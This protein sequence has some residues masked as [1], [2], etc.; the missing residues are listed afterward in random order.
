[1]NDAA[2]LLRPGLLDGCCLAIVAA[3]AQDAAGF[4]GPLSALGAET[5]VAAAPALDLL[6]EAAVAV[7]LTAPGR[8]DAVVVDGAG[9]FAA[10]LPPDGLVPLRACVDAAWVACR[11]AT[12][13]A[14]LPGAVEGKLI[15]VAPGPEAG[16]HAAAARAALENMARELSIEWARHGIRITAITPGVA[17]TSGEVAALAAYLASPAGDYA[18]GCRFAL[19]ETGPAA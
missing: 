19:G 16:P 5:L 1:V 15:L 17:T 11:A 9:L 3:S 13:A 7:A 10:A 6:D 4:E 14:F 2:Q 18:S 8:I 12:N